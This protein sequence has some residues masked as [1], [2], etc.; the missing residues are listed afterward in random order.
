MGLETLE[1]LE[2]TEMGVGVVESDDE[3]HRDLV[4]FEVIEERAAVGRA[5]ERP[6]QGVHDEPLL[7]LRGVDLPQLL[8]ADP[9][10]LRIDSGAQ[11]EALEQR[12]G[13]VTAAAFGE[14]RDPRV[15]LDSRLEASFRLPVA[16]DPHVLGRDAPDRAV[17]VVEHLRR[18]KSGKYG[19][20]KRLR[21]LSQP[22]A[23]VSEADDVVP[24]VVHLRRCGEPHRAALGEEEEPIVSRGRVE[25]RA[26]LLPVGEQ[27]LERARFH[28]RA[29]EDVG[30]DFGAL[31]DDANRQVGAV[32]L[33]ELPQSDRGREPRR[34]RPDDD[35]IELHRLAFHV[36]SSLPN[37]RCTGDFGIFVALQQ[38][39]K[40]Q[41][42]ACRES[43]N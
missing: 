18:R 41:R 8:D 9:V 6:S 5:V 16:C 13:Q 32:F 43:R 25:R 19:D 21:L 35:H 31:F 26:A 38:R 36:H 11:V 42:I 3:P 20:I 34:S 2:R 4:V 40:V 14:D 17:F 15:Q 22:A 7:M 24:L 10:G 1:F 39:S 23:K 37:P 30:S 28:H 29:G 33:A 27:L 12:L